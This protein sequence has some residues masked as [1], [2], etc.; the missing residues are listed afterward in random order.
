LIEPNF[1]L[2]GRAH[3]I[4]NDIFDLVSRPHNSAAVTVR[5]Q[6]SVG[7]EGGVQQT[8]VVAADACGPIVIDDPK[9]TRL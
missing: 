4:R 5:E 8:Y 7:I 9:D 2:E 1:I 6:V 3:G